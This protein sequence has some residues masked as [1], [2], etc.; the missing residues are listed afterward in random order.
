MT[1][2]L[3][4]LAWPEV[5]DDVLVIVP[6]GSTEQHGPHLPFTTDTEI[7]SAVAEYLAESCGGVL[8][9]PLAIGASGEHREFPGTVSLGTEALEAVLIELVRSVASW[10][11]RTVI[12][13]GHGGNIDALSSAVPRLRSEGHDVAWLPGAV[14]SLRDSHAGLAETSVMLALR[15]ESVRMALAAPG[16]TGPLAELMPV[17]TE[18]G[19]RALSPSG[20]LGDPSGATA[21]NGRLLLERLRAEARDRLSAGTPDERGC[22][23]WPGV[24]T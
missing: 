2:R 1:P 15:P 7:A 17:L 5:G 8:T 6:L 13:N 11:A 4:D 9:P 19:V 18:K 22:L 20:V 3:A 24:S 14:G 16:E 12:V 23:R 10:A 21:E